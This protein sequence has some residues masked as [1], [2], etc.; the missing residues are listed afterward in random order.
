MIQVAVR[1]YIYNTYIFV[2]NRN[3]SDSVILTKYVSKHAYIMLNFIHTKFEAMHDSKDRKK[4]N[5]A[6]KNINCNGRCNTM[7]YFFTAFLH[8]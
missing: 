7:E 5:C 1:M 2:I 8:C 4:T 6:N 3:N